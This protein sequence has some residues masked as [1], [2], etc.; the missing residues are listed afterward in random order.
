M[1]GVADLWTARNLWTGLL[2]G[3]S[4]EFD[5]SATC[6]DTLDNHLIF[7]RFRLSVGFGTSS[8][9]T[10]LRTSVVIMPPANRRLRG[11]GRIFPKSYAKDLRQAQTPARA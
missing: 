4:R 3:R 7:R 2:D 9:M 11:H 5:T 10:P 8:L 6:L 1:N